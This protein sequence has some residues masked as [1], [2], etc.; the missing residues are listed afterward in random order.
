[1][2]PRSHDLLSRFM[3]AARADAMDEST[4][5]TSWL[6]SSSPGATRCPR[7]SPRSSCSCPRTRKWL[8]PCAPSLPVTR[9]RHKGIGRTEPEEPDESAED[10]GNLTQPVRTR[11][12]NSHVYETP[13]S[14]EPY[15]YHNSRRFKP[16]EAAASGE[17]VD[18][19]IQFVLAELQKMEMHLGDR[20]DGRCSG[21]E[22]RVDEI[23]KK[24]DNVKLEVA[25]VNAFLERT[26][27]EKPHHPGIFYGS[28]YERPQAGSSAD[29]PH[30]YRVE[31]QHRDVEFG[32]YT[33][34][35]IPAKVPPRLDKSLSVPKTEDKHGMEAARANS[36][37]DNLRA[38][39][40]YRRARGLCDKCA[41]KWVYGHKCAAQV[42]LHAMQEVW[43]L[44]QGD[45]T[46]S[47]D[48]PLK[49]EDTAQTFITFNPTPIHAANTPGN[50][51]SVTFEHL[52]G[53]HYTHAVLFENM[54][55][56]PPV[57]FDSKFCA[58]DD[59]LPDGT[60][61][62]G[63]AR[64]MYHPYAMG[65]MPSIWGA[66]HH[67][68]RP[69]RWLTGPGNSF[70]PANLYKYPVFQAGVRVCLRKE[71]AITEMKAVAVA[72]V[73]AFD[74]EVV[75]RNGSGA[76]APKFVSGLTASIS[77]GLPVKIRSVRNQM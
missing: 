65:L 60:Y 34:T 46:V 61:V 30:G 51:A 72:V 4:S 56:F 24:V 12:A 49:E 5:T 39:R 45:D 38:L 37:D 27:W 25:C 77:G 75:D 8:Q 22:R 47:L 35:H 9:V 57:Q 26:H 62:S 44:F 70:V 73:R 71:L 64:V 7:L 19:T 2:I 13:I 18:P 50:E 3:T 32:D 58:G 41:K 14:M 21:L 31:Q 20:D 10:G 54:R 42:Q 63:G 69:K 6:A 59:V 29:G 52:K 33:H 16:D 67:A 36:T 11:R 28:A 68:F 15:P 74:V 43:E 17:A 66:D 1:M 23:K 55:L 40:N 76:C 48:Q 53:L